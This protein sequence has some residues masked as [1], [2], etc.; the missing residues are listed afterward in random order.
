MPADLTQSLAGLT[1]A[2]GKAPAKGS[3]GPTNEV[4]REVNGMRHKR[5]GAGDIFVSELGLG[6][7]VTLQVFP[8]WCQ[9]FPEWCQMFPEWFQMLRKHKS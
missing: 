5:L 6:T 2:A 7:Q 8:E 4:V 9:M 1:Q 3:T